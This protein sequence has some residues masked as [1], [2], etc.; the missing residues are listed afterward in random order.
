MDASG[1]ADSRKR[2]VAAYLREASADADGRRLLSTIAPGTP[3][4]FSFRSSSVMVFWRKETSGMPQKLV[5]TVC[6]RTTLANFS[7][8]SPMMSLNPTLHKT[9]VEH[10]TSGGADGRER[11]AAAYFSSNNVE[12]LL[13]ASARCFAPSG[14][15]RLS[16]KLQTRVK[17]TSQ[18]ALTPSQKR[19]HKTHL[20]D[21]NEVFTL[22]ISVSAM[23][24]S[25][26]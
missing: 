12:L 10:Q 11:C 24:P 22:S 19:A 9:R 16:N 14:P 6:S 15:T 8:P 18:R 5:S 26:V 20:M 3:T 4:P 2:C 21:C 23:M 13:R 25:A 1:G 7:A 17:H